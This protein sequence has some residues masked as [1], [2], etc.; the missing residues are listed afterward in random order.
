MNLKDKDLLTKQVEKLEEVLSVL[1]TSFED[2][3]ENEISSLEIVKTNI[4]KSVKD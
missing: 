1:W 4:T 2:A 3:F